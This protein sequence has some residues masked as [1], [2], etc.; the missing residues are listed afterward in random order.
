MGQL[1]GLSCLALFL[2]LILLSYC[3]PNI[4]AV[5]AEHVKKEICP[6][7]SCTREEQTSCL[8]CF[9]YLSPKAALLWRPT[10]LD[11]N[12]NSIERVPTC[13]LKLG[14]GWLHKS[15]VKLHLSLRYEKMSLQTKQGGEKDGVQHTS[16]RACHIS[17]SCKA[18]TLGVRNLFNSFTM[19]KAILGINC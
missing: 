11:L 18:Q 6:L 4:V 19:I 17:V 16:F 7:T 15:Q 3:V 8:K 14:Q 2:I 10:H 13:Y 12:H 1:S 9:I 5:G